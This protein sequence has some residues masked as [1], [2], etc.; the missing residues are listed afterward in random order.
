MNAF[1]RCG[2]A[3]AAVVLCTGV[4]AQNGSRLTIED[5]VVVKFGANSGM[6]VH[7]ELQTRGV[8]NFTSVN[9]DAIAG[10][11]LPQTGMPASGDWL[12]IR[13]TPDVQP[14]RC[15]F[16]RANIRYAGQNGVAA[17]EVQ[18]N[19]ELQGVKISQ[20]DVGLAISRGAA[21]NF[22]EF[23]LGSN[24]IGVQSNGAMATLRDS[25]V[26]GNSAFGASNVTIAIPTDAKQNY[27]GAASGP[28]D[29]FDNPSGTGD[30]VT[31]GVDYG[32][33]LANAP[34]LGCTIKPADGRYATNVRNVQMLTECEGAIELRLSESRLYSGSVYTPLSSSRPFTLSELEG[35]KT[36]YAQFRGAGG[37]TRETFIKM[38]L[39]NSGALINITNPA[40]GSIFTTTEL[41]TIEAQVEPIDASVV[42]AVNFFLNGFLI[43]TDNNSPYLATWNPTGYGNGVYEVKAVVTTS[44]GSSSLSTI[45]VV[46]RLPGGPLD[47]A[48]PVVTDL[49]FNGVPLVPGA[50]ITNVG[51]L[52]ATISDTGCAS[53]CAVRTTV[54]LND[55]PAGTDSFTTS[56]YRQ[57]LGF[58]KILNGP[59]RLRL[60]AQDNAGNTTTVERNLTLL[61]G[62]PNV[63]VI[64][65]PPQNQIVRVNPISVYGTADA[66]ARVQLY[67]NN[68]P[69]S[70]PRIASEAGT[71]EYTQ[72]Q[73]PSEGTL[74]LSA[75][76]TNG[77]GTSARTPNR[78]IQF[79]IPPASIVVSQ[80]IAGALVVGP[81]TLAASVINLRGGTTVEFFVNNVS[82]GVD[83]S[84]PYSVAFTGVGQSDGVKNVR[85]LMRDTSNS[86][87]QA[88]SA[89]IYR[90]LPAVVPE[91]IPP[92][93]GTGLSALPAISSG[94]VP[95]VITGRV[96]ETDTPAGQPN[97]AVTLV[98]RTL[99]FERRVNVVS[100]ANGD[101]SYSYMPRTSDEGAFQVFA[102]HPQAKPFVNATPTGVANFTLQRLSATPAR[103]A[104]QAPR[105][106]GQPFAITVRNSAGAIA[107]NVRLIVRTQDQP[108]NA[109]P[110]GITFDG[111]PAQNIAEGGEASFPVQF[112][113]TQSS[114]ASG[115]LIV[116]VLED[117]SGTLKRGSTR[118]DYELYPA[119]PALV[120][121]PSAI[122][123]GVRRN[124]VA[125]ETFTL[126][127]K[128][129][130]PATNVQIQLLALAPA[131]SVPSWIT[132]V[133][134]T[135]IASMAVGERRTLELRFAPGSAVNDAVYGAKLRITGANATGTEQPIAAA[136]SEAGEGRV[137]FHAA[138]IFTQ[139]LD[140]SNLLIPGLANARIELTLEANPLIRA[141]GAT[142][143][144]GELLL[145]PLPPGRYTYRAQ[146]PTHS[147]SS[148]RVLLRAGATVDEDVFLDFTTVSFTW[149][150]TP[151][152]ILDIYNIT[153]SATYSTVVPAPVVVIEPGVV[154]I[155]ELSVGQFTTGELTVTN[156]GLLRAD[157]VVLDRSTINPFFRIDIF[158]DMPNELQPGQRVDLLYRIT[159]LQDLPNSTNATSRA[160]EL[161]TWLNSKPGS[162]ARAPS[163]T[164]CN[165]FERKIRID[166]GYVCAN[167]V[168]RRTQTTSSFN[169]TYGPA[170]SLPVIPV[171]VIGPC[172]AGNLS[173]GGGGGYAG[174]GG[175]GGATP[176]GCGP[177]CTQGCACTSGCTKPD[178]TP[179]KPDDPDD[180]DGPPK[181]PSCTR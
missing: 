175:G 124:Q 68:V 34:L 116:T 64:T 4:L 117:G 9:D 47:T 128:G 90:A 137:R 91:F 127:N 122:S 33:Y 148:G 133:S 77:Q 10:Q 84:E 115:N 149:A 66:G 106:F 76:A 19:Q 7:Q 131:T 100:E 27:W 92:Y 108:G 26:N 95:I 138:D 6:V 101:F 169:S 35:D 142:N 177:D 80:P 32:N 17:L 41:V 165:A 78:T 60:E 29:P 63:P 96:R 87:I 179:G 155:P 156:F 153:L 102:M 69:V 93:V 18:S 118:I 52:T 171:T 65:A 161:S 46:L 39:Q 159:A 181:P 158:G 55:I 167:G 140:Q 2:I 94:N 143:A 11:T 112:F 150:V 145:G 135:Q 164:G 15:R 89:F 36:I 99:G 51:N 70:P 3:F 85:V 119:L 8:V 43:G 146:G 23:S 109:F 162:V 103:I 107:N 163:A 45:S 172:A 160:A 121:S 81:S 110:V 62:P 54:F 134:P 38:H 53:N 73:L 21:A 79:I 120:V 111:G 151:T 105:G 176:V 14:L 97:S 123:T 126:E 13:I 71:F 58:V 72:V 136:V 166:F 130:V 59:L 139:T 86:T 125:T 5:G 114:P 50:T 132:L 37:Q 129:L 31:R 67:I 42:S 16:E 144:L 20:S 82:F 174:G 113:S 178:P 104:L 157:G 173:C 24:R 147:P 154:N 168:V 48:P 40:A 49:R 57:Y 180:P 83:T 1:F 30:K 141:E 44:L 28:F 152:T 12:G 25:V 56:N 22:R 170:C 74:Q 88:T 75:D 98:L 61:L